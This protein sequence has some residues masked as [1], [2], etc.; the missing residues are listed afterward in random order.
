MNIRSRILGGCMFYRIYRKKLIFFYIICLVFSVITKAQNE[1]RI[2]Y[3]LSTYLQEVNLQN[4]MLLSLQKSSNAINEKYQNTNVELSPYM[5][6]SGSLIDD[7]SLKQNSP[8]YIIDRQKIKDYSLIFGKK[9]RTGTTLQ[10]IAEAQDINMEGRSP[11]SF[12]ATQGVSHLGIMFSQSLWKDFFGH[13]NTLKAQRESVLE[14][15]EKVMNSIQINQVLI[16]AEKLYWD[17]I[18]SKKEL[19]L[20]ESSLNRAKKIQ[21]WVQRRLNDGIG[22]R[23]ELL[24]SQGLVSLRELQLVSANDEF[25]NIKIKIANTLER[26]S[27]FEFEPT[28]N[29]ESERELT[30]NKMI[31]LDAYAS[32][33]ESQIKVNIVHEV[34]ETQ[35]AELSLD[36]M[37]KTN[38]YDSNFNTVVGKI[39]DS[40]RP[41]TSIGLKFKWLFDDGAKSSIINSSQL[42]MQASH[43]KKEKMI[44]E[45]TTSWSEIVRRHSEMS[46]KIKIARQMNAFQKERFKSEQDKLSK[47]RTITSQV[48]TAEGDV[49]DSELSLMKLLTEQRKLEAQAKMFIQLED[50][51]L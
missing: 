20:H 13:S 49:A 47:G 10:L 37:Y 3:D 41:T 27:V 9:F 15:L 14:K 35:K 50:G 30:K 18:Y 24:S 43:L 34:K 12:Q 17:F 38:N 11:A 45:S 36:G 39:A 7:R 16:D 29:F 46:N 42:E 48:I 44:Q 33:L 32:H 5:Q 1:P 19:E 23:S 28:E 2:K 6:I 21:S 8:T 22:D 25:Q 51:M 31:R 4:K 26:A 40:E